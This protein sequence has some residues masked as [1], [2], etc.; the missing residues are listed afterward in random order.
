MEIGQ[1]ARPLSFVLN[2]LRGN[3]VNPAGPAH[4]YQPVGVTISGALMLTSVAAVRSASA[5]GPGGR[6]GLPDRPDNLRIPIFNAQLDVFFTVDTN[7][8]PILNVSSGS[9]GAE[10][11]GVMCPASSARCRT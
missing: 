3:T 6:Y 5:V 4:A 11:L 1:S 2:R 8:V 9:P 10:L 7:G